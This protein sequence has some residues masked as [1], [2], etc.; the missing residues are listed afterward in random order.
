MSR[1]MSAG[2]SGWELL[3]RRPLI[4]L[5]GTNGSGKGEAAARLRALGYAYLSLSDVIRE[6]LR[7]DGLVESRDAMIV[8]GNALRRAFGPDVLARRVLARVQGPTVIDSVRNPAEVAFLRG[9]GAFFLLAFDAPPA[10]RFERVGLRG[11][12]ESAADLE[13]FLR[14]E[15]EERGSDPEAQQLDACIALAD[16][17]IF[18]D[19]TIENLHRRLEEAL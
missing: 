9:G 7:R 15:A 6:E 4:G 19:G 14:K 11:R 10:V 2:A 17:R 18:N 3:Q 1:P 5:T 12:D 8:R 16:V 13:A